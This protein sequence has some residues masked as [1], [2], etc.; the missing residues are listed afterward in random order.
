VKVAD[1]IQDSKNANKGTKR[2][3]E[4][5]RE[6]LKRFGAARSVVTDRNDVLIAGNKTAEQAR[7]AGI[8]DVIVV[9]TDG[10]KLV[11]VKRIDLDM[12]EQKAQALAIADNRAGEVGL[13]WSKNDLADLVGV[14]DMDLQPFFTDDELATLLDHPPDFGPASE[15]EQGKL[16]ERKPI[17]CPNCGHTFNP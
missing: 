14:G 17:E 11:V 4:L 7:A 16:D 8:S 10:S 5:V 13:E 1:L 3:R 15:N 6:S 12:G 9:E 2:G